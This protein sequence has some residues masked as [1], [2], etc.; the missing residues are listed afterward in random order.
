MPL[1]ADA[2][3]FDHDP[4]VFD[5]DLVAFLEKFYT[6]SDSREASNDWVACFAEDAVLTKGA[7]QAKGPKGAWIYI[8]ICQRPN[9]N[10][11]PCRATRDQYLVVRGANL[12]EAHHP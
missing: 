11:G 4:A 5:R 1:S 8:T 2:Y 10:H 7:F 6:S 12:A 9:T 3:K